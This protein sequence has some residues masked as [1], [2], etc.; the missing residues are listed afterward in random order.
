VATIRSPAKM[1]ACAASICALVLVAAAASAGAEGVIPVEGPW[2]A[3]TS[4]G[5]PVTF[6]VKAGQ[7]VAP[8]FQFN[9][10]YCGTMSAAVGQPVPIEPGGHW[11]Y[12]QGGPYIEATF[13]APDRAEGVVVAPSRMT[14]S[15]GET[16]ATFVAKPGNV[17]FPKSESVVPVG[18]GEAGNWV[19][20]PKQMSLRSDGSIRF[21]DL[22]WHGFGRPTARANGRAYLRSGAVV[23]RPKVTVWLT[24][25]L[26]EEGFD[27]YETLR[28]AI[29]G[30]V[31]NG[32]RHK[33]GHI[34]VI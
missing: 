2:H 19:H 28:Y 29:H 22:H 27:V 20:A 10:G 34:Y 25:P 31:P 13:V 15:C 5:L 33:G 17:P 9:W 30:R 3:T 11:K 21:Y 14:P 23:R 26:E 7:V 8:R 12:E 6:E 4:A 1:V 16:R 18:V 32:F 24:Y